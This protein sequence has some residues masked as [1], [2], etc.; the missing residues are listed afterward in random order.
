MTLDEA[1]AEFEAGFTVH[2][3]MGFPAGEHGRVIDLSRAPCDEPYV[4]VISG[5]VRRQ[6]DPVPIWYAFEEDAV[7]AWVAMARVHAEGRG[8]HLYWRERPR[9]EAEDFVAV[10]QARMVGD[11]RTRADIALNIGYVYSRLLVSN[12]RPDGAEDP[13][14]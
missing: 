11:P 7:E 8:R 6:G 14:A 12:L 4:V 1:V 2:V 10:N 3:E 9:W 13:D 5:A